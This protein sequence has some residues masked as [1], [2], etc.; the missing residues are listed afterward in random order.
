MIN[1]CTCKYE[2][3]FLNIYFYVDHQINE[4]KIEFKYFFN[5]YKLLW[6]FIIFSKIMD[7]FA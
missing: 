1:L 3:L 5:F 7:F 2:Y 4:G 6:E